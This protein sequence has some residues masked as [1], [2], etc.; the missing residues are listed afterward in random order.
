MNITFNTNN[1]VLYVVNIGEKVKINNPTLFGDRL[2]SEYPLTEVR[3]S[4]NGNETNT[5]VVIC[6][7]YNSHLDLDILNQLL[8]LLKRKIFCFVVM[9]SSREMDFLIQLQ[10]INHPTS[11]IS[12]LNELKK[13]EYM[14]IQCDESPTFQTT[15]KTLWR[16]IYKPGPADAPFK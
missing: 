11:K 1:H 5:L 4:D 10:I 12:T 13:Y 15:N 9:G 8:D 3:Y 6:T 7:K 16:W 2:G 14:P